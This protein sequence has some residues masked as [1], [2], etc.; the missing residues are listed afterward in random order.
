MLISGVNGGTVATQ[1]RVTHLFQAMCSCRATSQGQSCRDR[2]C[3]L[4]LVREAKKR[5]R[6]TGAVPLLYQTRRIRLI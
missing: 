6:V 5:Q 1:R 4:I 2:L 3:K